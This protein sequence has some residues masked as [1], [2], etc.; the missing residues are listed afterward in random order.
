MKNVRTL[1][2]LM[3]CILMS[4][5]T[6][7]VFAQED[8]NEN[9]KA[10]IKIVKKVDGETTVIDRTIKLQN[11]ESLEDA[12]ERT[13]LNKEIE[14]VEE[15][16]KDV[17]IDVHTDVHTNGKRTKK[18]KKVIIIEEDGESKKMDLE[19]GTHLNFNTDGDKNVEIIEKDGVNTIIIKDNDGVEKIIEIKGNDVKVNGESKDVMYFH[20]GEKCCKKGEEGNCCANKMKK[21][22]K[23]KHNSNKASLGVMLSQEI[24][25]ENGVETN[26]GIVVKEVVKE[27]AAEAAGL[28]A[29]D[30][31]KAVDGKEVADS[32]ELVEALGKFDV[33]DKVK[34]GYERDGKRASTEATLK[35]NT[36]QWTSH[37]ESDDN[38]K[39]IIKKRIGENG[40][41]MDEVM[42]LLE[43]IEVEKGSA[44]EVFI[45]KRTED[46]EE[47]EIEKIM[48]GLESE[49]GKKTGRRVMI[50]K[51]EDGKVTKKEMNFNVWIQ[52][53]ETTDVDKIE[54]SSLKKAAA[55][56]TLTVESLQFYPNP[57]D[58]RFD[59][60]FNLPSKGKTV[61]RVVDMAG[62]E[63]FQDKLGNFSGTYEK[64]IDI[65]NN[66]KGVY[67]LQV[68][69]GDKVMMKKIVV[70]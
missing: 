60:S 8:T 52:D 36:H 3:V 42:E 18:M 69:Q 41:E 53:V 45:I 20:K 4:C 13:G 37:G 39:I 44:G 62:K 14:A 17:N 54:N 64:Q 63:V 47:V 46:G 2:L 7:N 65:S 29:G 48:E 22:E 34:I 30:I 26:S 58:G 67:F 21:V 38:H 50:F 27:S 40:E 68:E 9:R 28:K 51:D 55:E 6:F 10:T 61:V 1:Q 16:G 23:I 25:N 19:E 57:S 49:D 15:S 56:N 11:G 12:M 66:T 31:I 43:D 35:A 5:M 33:G 24:T 70:Q 32:K 59:I